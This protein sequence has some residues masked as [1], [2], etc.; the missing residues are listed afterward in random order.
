MPMGTFPSIGNVPKVILCC[1]RFK[2]EECPGFSFFL[3]SCYA[4]IAYHN[5]HVISCIIVKMS[6]PVR[7]IS[8]HQ[9]LQAD[10]HRR[11]K[12][13]YRLKAGDLVLVE[14]AALGIVVDGRSVGTVWRISVCFVAKVYEVRRSRLGDQRH[15]N[16]YAVYIVLVRQLA[17]ADAVIFRLF[18][19]G[20]AFNIYLPVSCRSGCRR[21]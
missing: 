1:C 6:E 10:Y 15:G 5:P 11:R 13:H 7:L 14:D 19:N 17:I 16:H 9:S 20:C 21:N 18:D 4:R 3:K 2:A 8:P 12:L